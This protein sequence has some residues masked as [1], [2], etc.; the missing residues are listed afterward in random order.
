MTAPSACFEVLLTSAVS[1]LRLDHEAFSTVGRRFCDDVRVQG[2]GV[3]FQGV[4]SRRKAAALVRALTA[5]LSV[6]AGAQLRFTLS[7]PLFSSTGRPW[8]SARLLALPKY[9]PHPKDPR[10]RRSVVQPPGQGVPGSAGN[11]GAE[12]GFQ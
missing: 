9:D 5:S 2:E 11:S 3:V 6:R 10:Q 4:P 12:G 1:P 8:T 7:E